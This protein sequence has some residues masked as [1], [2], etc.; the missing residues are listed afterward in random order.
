MIRNPFR[1]GDPVYDMSF[2]LYAMEKEGLLMTKTGRLNHL[3]D[4]ITLWGF[5]PTN[6]NDIAW[7]YDECCI[8]WELTTE[9]RD[10]VYEHT[11]ITLP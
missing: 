3:C 11:G 9:D 1:P 7:A 6:P 8:D 10:Y 5:D 2:N 4:V